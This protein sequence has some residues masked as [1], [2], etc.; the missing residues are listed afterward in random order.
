VIYS[1]VYVSAENKFQWKINPWSAFENL[2]RLA[3]YIRKKNHCI[4]RLWLN[5]LNAAHGLGDSDLHTVFRSVAVDK[6][7]YARS[8]WSGYVNKRDE[9]RIDAFLRR[10]KKCRFCQPDLSSFL[11]LCDTADEKLFDKIQYNKHHLLRYLLPPSSAASQSYN[12]RR[13]PH[14]QLLPQHPGHLMDS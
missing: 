3:E 10:K 8:A 6:I 9:Q 14:S 1:H 11:E 12:L 5:C 13:R 7:T 4:K 2:R